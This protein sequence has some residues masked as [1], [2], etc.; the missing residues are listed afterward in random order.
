MML[1]TIE[2]D[3]TTGATHECDTRCEQP[4][5]GTEED[6]GTI[7][8]LDADQATITPGTGIDARDHHAFGEIR[9]GARQRQRRGAHVE[10][11]DVVRQIDDRDVRSLLADDGLHH[12]DVFGTEPEVRQER[13]RRESC[14]AHEH[15]VSV[16]TRNVVFLT[17]KTGP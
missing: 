6:A 15:S 9:N 4:V 7:G 3:G 14:R 5:V 13:H 17:G 11:R 16:R 10:R 8:H 2:H 1:V 12:A